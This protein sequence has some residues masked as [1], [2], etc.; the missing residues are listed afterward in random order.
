[1]VAKTM[2]QVINDWKEVISWSIYHVSDIVALRNRQT[3]TAP[4]PPLSTC[5]CNKLNAITKSIARD[6][7]LM[8]ALVWHLTGSRSHRC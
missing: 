4:F 6:D 1:M 3:P 8:A 7:R 5:L 2:N